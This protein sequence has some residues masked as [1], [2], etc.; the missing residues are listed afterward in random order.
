MKKA[1]HIA[2]AV[3]FLA[4][5]LVVSNYSQSKP[6][7]TNADIV[8]MVKSGLS[9]AVIKSAIDTNFVKF[10]TSTPALKN[11][12]SKRVSPTIITHM[13]QK[14]ASQ[15]KASAV[16]AKRPGT[17]RIGLV[18]TI[19]SAPLE[20]NL[21]VQ[22]KLFDTFYGNR[23][24]S[25]TEIVLLREKLDVN[26]FAESLKRGCD[27]VLFLNLD[28]EIVSAEKKHGVRLSQLVAAVTQGLGV[29]QQSV[30]PASKAY[31]YAERGTQAGTSM[32]NANELMTLISDVTKK[33]NKIALRYRFAKVSN[34]EFLLSETVKEVIAK[35]DREPILNN[36]LI[37]IGNQIAP[38][39][40]Q[41]KP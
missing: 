16:T 3:L 9:V 4:I 32:Q 2:E 34:Q 10:D 39:F 30:D 27:F 17:V 31:A 6:A 12:R 8:T 36:I 24:T 22:A 15:A 29:A 13:V 23:D 28:S 1:K 38:M 35:R 21:A 20:Q 33:K 26:I 19:S 41:R 5:C 25:L 37:E 14:A 11:L 18:T 7:L 40:V